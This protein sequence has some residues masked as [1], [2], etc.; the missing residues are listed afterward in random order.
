MT[1]PLRV[2]GTATLRPRLLAVFA[3][4]DDES[5]GPGGTL[6]LYSWAGA[7]V[8][9]VCTTGGEAGVI[10]D[11]ILE[12]YGSAVAARTAELQCAAARLGLAGLELLGYRDSGMA[13]AA[14]N[15][16]P[17]A[18]Y[19]APLDEV[20]GRIMHTM[21]AVRPHVVITFDPIGG[22][23]HPDHIVTQQATVRAFYAAG[24]PDIPDDLPPYK[25]Q[26]LYFVVFPKG[27][28][29]L[30]VRLMPLFGKD[31]RRFGRNQDVDL[32]RLFDTE[33]P[34]HARIDYREVEAQREAAVQC[35]ASQ[36]RNPTLTQSIIGALG[37][38]FAGGETFMRAYPPAE[39]GTI[40]RDLFAGVQVDE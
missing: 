1:D 35:H 16:H 31:P 20:T 28:L 30:F 37:R 33:F 38:L 10:D 4:P 25:P 19:N 6:A 40:E 24:D 3:H 2:E 5:F 14:D 13:G 9:L 26:K 21:R 23:R 39:P 29:K 18:L 22:Y 15:Q 36:I 7:A 32:T 8:Y 11:D 27:L 17:Q 12:R 34:V